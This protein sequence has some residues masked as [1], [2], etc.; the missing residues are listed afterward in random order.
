M[1]GRGK[2]G[3]GLGKGGAKRHRKVLRDN[4]QGIT[5]PAIR[6]LARRGGVKRISGRI[7]EECRG[8]LKVFLEHVIR[9]AVTYA[10]HCRRKTVIAMDV[11]YAL[12][13]Q[14]RTLYGFG[15]GGGESFGGGGALVRASKRNKKKKPVIVGPVRGPSVPH[16][17]QEPQRPH[18][19]PPGPVEP[20]SSSDDSSSDEEK[21]DE[22][23]SDAGNGDSDSM[24]DD[25]EDM[26]ERER[27]H[28]TI[29]RHFDDANS[30]EK[31]EESTHE[32][33][34]KL[35][36][37][38]LVDIES[39][40]HQSVGTHL[41]VHG[42]TS[43]NPRSIDKLLEEMKTTDKKMGVCGHG[44]KFIQY[45]ESALGGYNDTDN[46]NNADDAENG[47]N[48]DKMLT[49]YWRRLQVFMKEKNHRTYVIKT[50]PNASDQDQPPQIIAFAIVT[51]SEYGNLS[52]LRLKNEGSEKG[53]SEM[54]VFVQLKSLCARTL[55]GTVDNVGMRL[56]R[57]AA[58]DAF[59][60][61]CQEQEEESDL[62]KFRFVAGLTRMEIESHKSK[63]DNNGR[64][65]SL[66][67]DDDY[68]KPL[69]VND[70]LT[71]KLVQ[72][73]KSEFDMEFIATLWNQGA[74]DIK[75]DM[76]FRDKIRNE[77]LD[78]VGYL[79]LIH[80]APDSEPDSDSGSDLDKHK[81]IMDPTW[82]KG[83]V[84]KTLAKFGLKNEQVSSDKIP[85]G[86]YKP[87]S[88]KDKA[89]QYLYDPFNGE[90]WLTTKAQ[91]LDAFAVTK[92]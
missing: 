43:S 57:I 60:K 91:T 39:S 35:C 69:A 87:K 19:P 61:H 1:S 15:G 68:E 88:A 92:E 77:A 79:A 17:P 72:K 75:N 65:A 16:S 76:L 25:D 47:E 84:T 34:K 70:P 73:Y 74:F 30:D 55:S 20:V 6:R 14:G 37:E 83:S 62:R 46:A 56:S 23:K 26:I 81:Y 31:E 51:V 29:V 64:Y 82:Y 22:K 7:Y 21:G 2:G 41:Q 18:S 5:K 38:L 42:Y 4:I 85:K 63:K 49:F 3:K 78:D 36:L 33:V 90:M 67:S 58:A 45:L 54:G 13:R 53:I 12:K 28:Q 32:K 11:V 89:M 50:N 48:N 86:L 80:A 71:T 40:A 66:T 8:V 59:Y 10:D 44:A 9:D 52:L 27:E 24:S